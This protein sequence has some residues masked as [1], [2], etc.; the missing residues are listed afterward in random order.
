[1]FRFIPLSAVVLLY[2]LPL[3]CSANRL[4]AS[5]LPRLNWE[6]RSDWLNVRQ[7]GAKGD[8][9]A[10]DTQAIQ[11]AFD[12]VTSGTT[13]YLPKGTYRITQSL[14]LTGPATGVLI[15]GHGR[16][17]KLVW[18]GVEGGRMLHDDGLST[19]R[20]VGLDLDGGGTAAVGFYHHS[21]KR[22]ETEVEHKHLAFRN[23]TDAGLMA[24]KDDRY[25]LAETTIENCLFEKLPPRCLLLQLQ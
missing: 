17:T 16:D 8:G 18:G 3:F 23:F 9:R 24:A 10:D 11:A 5:E 21:M 14:T 13:V 25:A 20:Y 22:F 12:Q 4:L 2:S 15:V 6:P 1:M 19:S 7:F